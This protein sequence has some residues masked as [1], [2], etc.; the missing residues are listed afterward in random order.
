MLTTLGAGWFITTRITDH[1]DQVKKNRE[2]NL[3]AARDFQRLY[4]EAIAIWKTWNAMKGSHTAP[5][6]QPENAKWDCLLRATAME[7]EV[8][9]LLAKVAAERVLGDDDIAILGALRQAFKSLRRAIRADEPVQWRS[10]DVQQYATFKSLAAAMSV[11]LASKSP[12]KNR[13]DATTAA[14]A[15]QQITA[16]HHEDEWF[17]AVSSRPL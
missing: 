17:D 15:F 7:G 4:G 16:N 10:D 5:F 1:W 11:L 9:S 3:T 12:T 8:E 2:L 6:T 14:R 13:P